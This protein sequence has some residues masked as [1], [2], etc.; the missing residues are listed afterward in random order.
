MSSS[1]DLL[2]TKEIA[3]KPKLSSRHKVFVVNKLLKIHFLNR[4]SQTTLLKSSHFIYL[5]VD[6]LGDKAGDLF[7]LSIAQYLL[8]FFF[9]KITSIFPQALFVKSQTSTLKRTETQ[10][11]F[12]KS[13]Y[14]IAHRMTNL[15]EKTI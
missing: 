8:N 10:S 7:L 9:F 13:K 11:A 3:A 4:L 14:K 5:R 6:V 2:I 12:H 15:L 1:K